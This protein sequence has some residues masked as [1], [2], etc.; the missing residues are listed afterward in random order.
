MTRMIVMDMARAFAA[1]CL[2]LLSTLPGLLIGGESAAPPR[3]A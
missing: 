2:V 3:R 1:R